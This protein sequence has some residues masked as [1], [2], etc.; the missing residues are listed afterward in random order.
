MG[1]QP[2]HPSVTDNSLSRTQAYL[3]RTQMMCC[4]CVWG[5]CPCFFGS[6]HCKEQ[7]WV[8]CLRTARWAYW[9]HQDSERRLIFRLSV[10]KFCAIW[11]FAQLRDCAAHSQ[12]PETSCQSSGAC[13]LWE[14][15]FPSLWVCAQRDPRPME[16]PPPPFLPARSRHQHV[17][18]LS[19]LFH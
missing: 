6:N 8:R 18:E 10:L 17:R 16:Y 5:A 2:Q 12:N 14:T 4:M 1:G 9:G 11:E 3:K 19:T 7:E 15:P 13:Q